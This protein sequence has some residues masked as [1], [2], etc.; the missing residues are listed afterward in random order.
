M[1]IDFV[2]FYHIKKI[3]FIV[4]SKNK[5]V[6]WLSKYATQA[7]QQRPE[8]P[9]V[10]LTWHACNYKVHKLHQKLATEVFVVVLVLHIS[11]AN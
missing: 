9:M 2:P 1:S 8:L 5:G 3:T 11:S 10:T 4:L 7:Q 6:N